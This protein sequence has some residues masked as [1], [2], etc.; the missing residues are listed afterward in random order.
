MNTASR[1][2]QKFGRRLKSIVLGALVF[3]VI[4]KALRKLTQ[5]MGQYLTANDDFA[6]ALSGIKSNL[7][8]AFQPIYEAVLP[9]LT[10]MLEKV[11]Q[12]TA[13][14]AQFV[15]SIF[16][17]TAKQAQENAK[18]LYEQ[19]DATEATG[20]AAKNAEK[21]LASFDTIEKVSKEENKTAP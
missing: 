7:L 12:L 20:K 18:A 4:S 9:A 17:T 21:F 14:M 2:M 15:A 1:S 13:Q 10:A 16:G 6:K 3:N 8:T 19:A 5:Q 11:E